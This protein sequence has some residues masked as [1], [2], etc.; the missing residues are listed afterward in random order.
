MDGIRRG[1]L[2]LADLDP[3]RGSEQ[4]G[5][6]PV[7]VLQNNIGNRYAR[8]VIVAPITG[9]V[10]RGLPTHV[11][12]P[13][14]CGLQKA[15]TVMLEQIRTLHKARLGSRLGWVSGKWMRRVDS[16]VAVSLG[17]GE[18]SR[19][20]TLCGRC[21]RAFRDN[22]GR[23]VVRLDP[24]QESTGTCAYCGSRAGFDYDV[25]EGAGLHGA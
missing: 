10:V 24:G 19:V 6:R 2:F 23:R 13:P 25:E 21:A 20:T 3:V 16:A 17:I 7:L 5:V 8:T 12:L 1:Q 9:K 14:R 15:S 11:V 4:G 18:P 22:G